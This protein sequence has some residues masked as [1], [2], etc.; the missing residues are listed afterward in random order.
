[1]EVDQFEGRQGPCISC[2]YEEEL[3]NNGLCSG[4]NPTDPETR[5]A[6]INLLKPTKEAQP[7]GNK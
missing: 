6:L 5:Q 1:M 7:Q 4:C 2:L 3:D